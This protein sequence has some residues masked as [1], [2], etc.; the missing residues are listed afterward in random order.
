MM[1]K[2]YECYSGSITASGQGKG[3]KAQWEEQ[4]RG[5]MFLT[6]SAH[7]SSAAAVQP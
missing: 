5:R 6:P 1:K 3:E 7:S 2:K 4:E